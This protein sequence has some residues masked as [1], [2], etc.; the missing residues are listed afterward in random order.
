MWVSGSVAFLA[1]ALIAA[2]LSGC[3]KKDE[4]TPPSPDPWFKDEAYSNVEV[5][6]SWSIDWNARL[7]VTDLDGDG[8]LDVV[9]RTWQGGL[10]SL[11]KN[12]GE[13]CWNVVQEGTNYFKEGTSKMEMVFADV[14]GDG[15]VDM[16]T[17]KTT[18]TDSFPQVALGDGNGHFSQSCNR[19]NV[20]ANYPQIPQMPCVGDIDGDEDLDILVPIADKNEGSAA[21]P[22]LF[23]NNGFGEFT[24]AKINGDE[25]LKSGA[26]RCLM[27]DYNSDGMMDILLYEGEQHVLYG[28]AA[29]ALFKQTAPLVFETKVLRPANKTMGADVHQSVKFADVNNDGRLDLFMNG[30]Y[31]REQYMTLLINTDGDNFQDVSATSGIPMKRSHVKAVGDFDGDGDLDFISWDWGGAWFDDPARTDLFLNDGKGSFRKAEGLLPD[32]GKDDSPISLGDINGDGAVDLVM[33]RYESVGYPRKARLQLLMNKRAPSHFLKVRAANGRTTLVGA[34]VR[35]VHAGTETPAAAM[36]FINPDGAYEDSPGI[37]QDASEALFVLSGAVAKGITSFDVKVL[38]GGQNWRTLATVNDTHGQTL[39]VDCGN[40]VAQAAVEARAQQRR[41]AEPNAVVC[42]L[43][44]PVFIENVKVGLRLSSYWVPLNGADAN[45]SYYGLHLDEA[46]GA[47]QQWLLRD[48][49]GGTVSIESKSAESLSVWRSDRTQPFRSSVGL[50]PCVGEWEKFTIISSGDGTVRIKNDV[51]YLATDQVQK[52]SARNEE[53]EEGK[54]TVKRV[55]DGTD[56][57]P[58]TAAGTAMQLV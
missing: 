23:L 48:A 5:T 55:S 52:L 11:I 36:A 29:T 38:C 26:Q 16:I 56:A 25:A 42:R 44:Q 40:S 20:N 2:G 17:P 4:P 53:K 33:Y 39:Q 51:F 27:V 32:Q 18:R 15:N 43:N 24:Y 3:G 30:G 50:A 35:V 19:I 22:N 13:N 57:C 9:V 37:G 10:V 14:D 7:A 1:A 6:P 28:S 8:K 12:C 46:S 54:W 34:Q 41:M 49:G 31:G 58:T 47:E 21:E 45:Y